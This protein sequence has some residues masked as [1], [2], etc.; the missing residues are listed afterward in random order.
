MSLLSSPAESA[1]YSGGRYQWAIAGIT[2]ASI[3]YRGFTSG[4]RKY[5]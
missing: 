4:F 3:G 1:R 2:S 5:T